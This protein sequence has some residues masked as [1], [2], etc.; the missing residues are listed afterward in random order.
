MISMPIKRYYP[1]SKL[2]Q[3]LIKYFWV[4]ESESPVSLNHKILPVSN[5]DIIFNLL[6]PMVYEK[7]GKL[8]P[9]PGRIYFSGLSNRYLV[10]K[11]QGMVF[12]I[13]ASLFHTGLYPLFQIPAVE[14]QDQTVG[15]EEILGKAVQGLELE[16]LEATTVPDKLI[17]LENFFL[18]QLIPDALPSSDTL[19]LFHRFQSSNQ[20]IAEFCRTH[21]IHPRQIERLFHKYIGASPKRYTRLQRF[22]NI[23]NRLEKTSGENLTYLAHDLNF[24]DQ[25]HFIK[26]FK[27]FTG[28]T[29]SQFIREKQSVKQIMKIV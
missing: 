2:L 25:T 8:F 23:L 28:S 5:V 14:F 4:F 6:S 22:L 29:P 20:R 26:D 12:T 21:K 16:L 13:G 27:S 1:K 19:Q 3:H 17:V 10:M 15:L 11:Q 24:Y 9:T 18:R 7:K